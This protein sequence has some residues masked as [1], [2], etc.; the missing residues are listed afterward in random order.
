MG[1]PAEVKVMWLGV[2]IILAIVGLSMAKVG[3]E[4][5]PPESEI[6]FFGGGLTLGLAIVCFLFHVLPGP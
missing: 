4:G 5:S 6:L 1:L 3:M 2:T